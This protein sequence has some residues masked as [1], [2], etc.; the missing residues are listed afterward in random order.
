VSPMVSIIIPAFNAM[1]Y[2]PETLESALSQTYENTEV[3]VV[4]DGSTDDV[5]QYVSGHPDSRVRLLRKANGG[6]ASARNKG[7]LSAKGD[8]MAFLDADDLWDATKLERQVRCLEAAKRVGLS[9]TGIRFID[10]IGNEVNKPLGVSG[11]GDVRD[12]VVLENPVRCGSTPV[13]RA[14]CFADVGGFDE[15]LRFAEDWDMWIRIAEKHHFNAISEPLTAY[16]QHASNM[17]KSHTVIMPNMLK[18]LDKAFAR[19]TDYAY[20][21]K[22]EAYGRAC[23]FAA[24]RAYFQRDY[25]LARQHQLRAFQHSPRL[26]FCRTN[27][28]L[29]L[30]ELSLCIP[31]AGGTRRGRPAAN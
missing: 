26:F 17:T 18:I 19:R 1:T 12:S 10:Q 29:M 2:L 5:V 27:I 14:R 28:S 16:R 9:H 31:M 21:L 24:W 11:N 3:L 13:V 25:D 15:T 20:G 8:Y 6:L 7:L 23:L 30:N 4:D 22:G